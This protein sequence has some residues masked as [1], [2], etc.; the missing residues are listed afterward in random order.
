[1]QFIWSYFSP[2]LVG[3]RLIYRMSCNIV[4]YLTFLAGKILLEYVIGDYSVSLIDGI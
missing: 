1:M 4:S 3:S 2:L